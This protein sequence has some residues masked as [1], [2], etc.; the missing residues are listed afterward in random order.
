MGLRFRRSL[1]ILPGVR[2]NFSKSGIST[3]IGRRGASFNIG[4][5]GKYLNL[6]LP[7]TGVSY[8]T[9]IP[10]HHDSSQHVQ[11][12]AG[13]GT[14]ESFVSWFVIGL[15]AIGAAILALFVFKP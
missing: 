6:G 2:L 3:T 15:L 1:K 8:R 14:S 9:K 13:S 7:G 11:P 12:P 5:R 10:E 4:P